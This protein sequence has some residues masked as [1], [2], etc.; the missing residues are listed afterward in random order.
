MVSLQQAGIGSGVEDL[1]KNPCAGRRCSFSHNMLNV[2]FD[3]LFSNEE[4]V[5]YFFIRPPFGQMFD[6]GLFTIG[7]LKLFPGV[8]RYVRC[9]WRS[10]SFRFWYWYVSLCEGDSAPYIQAECARKTTVYLN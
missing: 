4:S 9:S 10:A 1:D 6:H 5:C 2:L 7:E 3:G 8:V